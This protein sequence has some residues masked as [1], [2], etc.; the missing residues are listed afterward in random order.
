MLTAI[1]RTY[2]GSSAAFFRQLA[3]AMALL[4]PAVMSGKAW[5]ADIHQ[6][7]ASCAGGTCHAATKPL[8]ESGIR[9]DEYF[10]WQ[11]R[12]PHARA[13]LT[14]ASPLSQRMG[15]TL[16]IQP[17]TAAQC[18]GCHAEHIPVAQQGER[19]LASD[20]IGCESCH[21]GSERWL[22]PHTQPGLSLERKIALGMTPTWQPAA[23]A[24]LCQSCHQG[25][26]A[27]HPITHAMMAAGHP[28]LLF[29]LDTFTAL[30]SPHHDRDAD[31]VQRKGVQDSSLDWAVGQAM[32]A[33]RLLQSI[34]SGRVAQG[35]FPELVYFDCDACHHPMSAGRWLPGRNSGT[36]PGTPSLADASLYWVGLWLQ[37]SAPQVA[38]NW[39]RSTMQLQAATQTGLPQLRAAAKAARAL[40][41]QQVLPLVKT[42]T[43]TAAQ[44]KTLL[45]AVAATSSSPQA[46][47][48]LVAEQGAMA[49]VVISDTLSK[50]GVMPSA[51]QRKAVDGLFAVVG[52]REAFTPKD[53][54]E[55]LQRLDQSLR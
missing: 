49:A 54:R 50:R 11:Q 43:L 36:A 30:Q 44:L 6:G 23:R 32:A 20:G 9:R 8:G 17:T 24:A 41:Q 18:L 14:L 42:Q 15:R 53:Y 39:H 34:E 31:Y 7:V 16:G 1:T 35:L 4:A 26:D 48:F 47:N 51:A 5:S 2:C 13:A 12:D 45:N 25:G 40:L 55:A 33:D 22:A 27:A 37:A 19:W 46:N 29:E 21:G 10:I 3:I 52:N 38:A 28:A